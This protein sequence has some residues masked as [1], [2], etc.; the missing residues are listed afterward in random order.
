MINEELEF[1]IEQLDLLVKQWK[2]FYALYRK[3]SK[4]GEASPKEEREYAELATA[5]TRTYMPVATHVGLKPEGQSSVL[6]MVTDVPDAQAIRELSDMQ[7]RKFENDWRAN[8]TGMNQKLG[9]LQLLSEELQGVSEF[10]Y[11]GKRFLSNRVI[12]WT[13]GLSIVI[14]LLGLFGVF[15][16]IYRL[17][18]ELISRM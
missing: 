15:N 16:M 7:R 11:Y 14:V 6:S 9:E 8:N 17:L 5:L 18:H 10:T 4:P 3:I 13:L 2:R 12:Q 1:K